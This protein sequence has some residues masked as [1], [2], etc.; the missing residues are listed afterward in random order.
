[1]GQLFRP[2]GALQTV[3][4]GILCLILDMALKG[5]HINYKYFVSHVLLASS[6]SHIAIV[7]KRHEMLLLNLNQLKTV[8]TNSKKSRHLS[9]TDKSVML[10]FCLQ[11]VFVL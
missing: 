7:T 1:M 9:Q 2:S 3:R 8:I 11:E 4:V 5:I 6:S 10:C